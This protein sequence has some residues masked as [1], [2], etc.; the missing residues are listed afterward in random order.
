MNPPANAASRP[1]M[2]SRVR[3]I[4][5]QPLGGNWRWRRREPCIRPKK[6]RG[7]VRKWRRPRRRGGCRH[8]QRWSKAGRLMV[9]Q[10]A[11]LENRCEQTNPGPTEEISVEPGVV[12][13]AR[14][15]RV[16]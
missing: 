10:A 1:T 16:P 7:T 6:F 11:G 9:M 5:Y 3:W 4:P 8:N 12:R 2:T 13:G 14:Y 15:P